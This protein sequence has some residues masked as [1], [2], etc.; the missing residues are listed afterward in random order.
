MIE[1]R[2]LTQSS[3]PREPGGCPARKKSPAD[4]VLADAQRSMAVAM[5]LAPTLLIQG[6]E[7]QSSLLRLVPP[8]PLQRA[9]HFLSSRARPP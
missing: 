4:A 8:L 5:P 3:L 6:V 9:L 2:R 7:V 1:M